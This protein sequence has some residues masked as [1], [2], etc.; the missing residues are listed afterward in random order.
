MEFWL[1][2]VGGF[3]LYLV[4]KSMKKSSVVETRRSQVPHLKKDARASAASSNRISA[5]Y[6]D[7]DDENFVTFTISSGYEETK[8]KN[9][10]AGKWITSEESISV[11]GHTITKGNFY[12]GGQLSSLDGYGTEASLV[13]DSLEVSNL[14]LTYEDESLGYWPKYISISEGCRGAFLNWLASD[15][16]DPATPLGYVFIYFYGVERRVV[17]DS[18][19]GNVDDTEFKSIFDEIIRLKEIY[20]SSRSFVNYAIRLLEIMCLLRSNLVSHSELEKNPKQDSVLLKYKLAK[21][22]EEGKAIPANLA[23]AWLK[24][25]PD[26]SLR[27]PARRCA[28]EFSHMF[29]RL[30]SKKFDGGL[31]VKPN[32]TRLRIEYRPASSTL[33]GINIPHEDLPDPSNLKGP[34]KKLV[35]LADECIEALDAYSRYLGKSDTSRTDI[36]AVLLL[37]DELS[38]LGETLGLSKFKQWAE[39]CI[40]RQGGI[41]DVTEFWQFTKKPTPKKIN[42]KESELIQNL[43]GKSGFGVAPD[44]RYHYAKPSPD[45]KLVLFSGGHGKYFEPSKAFNEMGMALRL[46][47]MV[48]TIDSHV[49]ETEF[50]LLK[51]LIDHDTNLSPVEKRSLHAYLIWRLNTPS[52]V[53]GLKAR[54]EKLGSKEK[55]AVSKILIGVALADGKIDPDEIKQLEKLYKLLGLDKSLVTGDIHSLT[56]GKHI[57][58]AS[59]TPEAGLESSRSLQLDES[60]LAIH[61]SQTK[62]VQTMLSA[63]FVDEDSTGDAPTSEEY[64]IEQEDIGIDAQHYAL[65]ESLINRDRWSR[66]EMNELCKKLGLMVSG[67]I[68][69]INDWSFDKVDAPVLEEETDAVYV[70]QEIVEELEG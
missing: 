23:L 41:V 17:V 10:A 38:D 70:D 8:S 30:Y 54:L 11:K 68:E 3:V 5:R 24:F 26:Y 66:E 56:T 64:D 33:Q 28:Y 58:R 29:S 60:V 12:F 59:E 65:Y 50:A 6:K 63:I 62:D 48:A 47:A 37:P 4:I 32:K 42:K 53:T 13:D 51:Q 2:L 14:S 34:T 43:A 16:N 22:V 49:D 36:A 1:I 46:G 45:G 40:S 67:S 27:Q 21:A 35:S 44:T 20:G 52:N 15:R 31:V 69:T 55:E 18:I 57:Q 61:E 7:G 9:K 19:Q 25:I 39:G